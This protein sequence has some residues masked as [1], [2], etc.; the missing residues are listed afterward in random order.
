MIQQYMPSS[1]EPWSA[2]WRPMSPG[3]VRLVN[4]QLYTK[5]YPGMFSSDTCADCPD[6]PQYLVS[7]L[8]I[9]PS[10]CTDETMYEWP[11]Q[12]LWCGQCN[13]GG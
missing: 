3:S 4:G 13:I 7:R 9:P 5:Q 6:T 10:K 2:D 11:T 1:P 8:R 12:Y